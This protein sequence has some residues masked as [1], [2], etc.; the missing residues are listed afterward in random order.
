MIAS[1]D[2]P[3]SPYED[4]GA[5]HSSVTPERG[6][7]TLLQTD[8]YGFTKAVSQS[9]EP[10]ALRVAADLDEFSKLSSQHGGRVV[11]H[12]GD[13]LKVV[14]TS[15]VEAMRAAIEMQTYSL[16]MNAAGGAD[17][18]RIRH[19]IGVHM[20]DVIMV[21]PQILGKVPA[22]S[23]RLEE[24]C[25]PGKVCYSDDVHRA[26]AQ[27]IQFPRFFSGYQEV[28]N[29]A[30]TIKTWVASSPDDFSEDTAVVS[31]PSEYTVK[32]EIRAINEYKRGLTLGAIYG[33]LG[34]LVVVL[35]LWA[36]YVIANPP[37]PEGGDL[38][39]D[40]TELGSEQR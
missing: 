20:G 6:L 17:H 26:V 24:I 34:M 28:K 22:I 5:G 36:T 18:I 1:V 33:A 9:E 40:P 27:A 8:V 21:G 11:V 12:R 39:F 15:P 31:Q 10:V 23:M 37:K 30:T 3:E 35:V 32:S 2:K 4:E 7:F 29:V 25:P 13:G 19:R 16:A 38:K 14:F